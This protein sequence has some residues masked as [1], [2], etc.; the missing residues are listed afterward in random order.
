MQNVLMPT[1]FTAASFKL[2]E[3]ALKNCEKKINIV[4]FHAFALPDSP[5]DLLT[6]DYRKT[7]LSF[8]TEAFRA[9]CKQL[10]DAYPHMINKITVKCM[11]GNSAALFRNFAE[12]NDIDLICCPIGYNYLAIHARSINPLP[13]FKKSRIPQVK[14]ML[15][16]KEYV[17]NNKLI[18]NNEM[19]V[20]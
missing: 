16:S 7:E 3:Q 20:A 14:E 9:S 11:Q 2:I 6:N 12:A 17:F 8:M 10:K 18:F 15:K 19:A 13:L 1:D 4:L 5:F